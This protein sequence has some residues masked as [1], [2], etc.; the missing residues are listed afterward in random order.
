MARPSAAI[1]ESWRALD[2]VDRQ[3]RGAVDHARAGAA[4]MIEQRGRVEDRVLAGAQE[5]RHGDAVEARRGAGG[6]RSAGSQAPSGV[7][8]TIVDPAPIERREQRAEPLGMLVEDGEV[9]Q[10]D[11]FES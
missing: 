7:S 9:G 6:V 3:H 4:P 1:S 5:A 2:A 8:A 10:R 11:T